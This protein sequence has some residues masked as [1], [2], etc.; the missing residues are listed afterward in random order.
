MGVQ[1]R[2][3]YWRDRD[4]NERAWYDPRLFQKQGSRRPTRRAKSLHPAIVGLLCVLL[5]GGI[6]VAFVRW[7]APAVVKPIPAVDDAFQESQ[8]QSQRRVE[9][10]RRAEQQA[11]ID[12][13]AA[14][15]REFAE[16]QRIAA[17]ESIAAAQAD[18]RKARAWAKYY[19]SPPGCDAAATVECAND[20]IRARRVFEAEFAKGRL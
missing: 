9:E 1:D 7:R 14:V 4:R 12:Q 13:R 2:E 17:E 15:M 3:W 10:A 18:E 20:Q 5:L 16:R 19:R 6:S 11:L 8:R